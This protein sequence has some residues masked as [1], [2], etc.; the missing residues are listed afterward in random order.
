MSI[1]LVLLWVWNL[2]KFEQQICTRPDGLA[3]SPSETDDGKPWEELLKS[4]IAS[5]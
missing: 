2:Q 5:S 4:R 1:I 3:V